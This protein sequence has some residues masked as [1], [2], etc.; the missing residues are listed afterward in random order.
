MYVCTDS[1]SVNI[2][3]ALLSVYYVTNSQF[4]SRTHYFRNRAPKF[5]LYNRGGQKERVKSLNGIF[6]GFSACD[7][8]R[9]TVDR[10]TLSDAQLLGDL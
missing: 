1:H 4:H 3:A 7:L 9:L 5:M 6:R 10:P 8:P 2:L